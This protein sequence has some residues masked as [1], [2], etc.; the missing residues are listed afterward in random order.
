MT[1]EATSHLDL[2][3]MVAF[4]DAF[5][6]DLAHLAHAASRHRA[7]LD[8]PTRHTAVLAGWEL[9]KTQL[10]IHHTAEDE[11]LWPRMRTH[12]ADRPDEL[13][14]CRPCGTST[15]ASTRCW[16]RSRARLPTATAATGVWG[17][18]G[19]PGRRAAG[20]SWPQGA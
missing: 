20:A 7:Q 3:L 5:R 14:C 11:D 17:H 15:P 4:H 1:S 9:F 10:H 19:R 16:R 13:A 6:R 18:R 12:L 8:E 2:T